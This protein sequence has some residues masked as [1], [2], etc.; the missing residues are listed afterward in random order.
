M[1]PAKL[2]QAKKKLRKV[3]DEA[4]RTELELDLLK[5]G[6]EQDVAQVVRTLRS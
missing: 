3:I 5:Q 1:D 6:L 2:E 4:A